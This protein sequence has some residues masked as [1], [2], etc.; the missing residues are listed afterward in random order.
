[1]KI[2][3]LPFPKLD[4]AEDAA[5]DARAEA[6]IDAGRCVDHSKVAEWLKGWGTPDE[7]PIPP[8]WLA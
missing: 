6:D 4:P 7:K 8:E 2:E 1:M 3:R 5:A